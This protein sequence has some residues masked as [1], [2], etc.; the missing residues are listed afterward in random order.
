MYNI[1][2]ALIPSVLRNGDV[3]LMS[4]QLMSRTYKPP[5]AAFGVSLHVSR[6]RSSVTWLVSSTTTWHSTPSDLWILSYRASFRCR[7][8]LAGDVLEFRIARMRR[9]INLAAKRSREYLHT[10]REVKGSGART[11]GFGIFIKSSH[12]K[13]SF[14]ALPQ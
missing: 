5:P 3:W 10:S 12:V 14:Y 9:R 6:Q 8:L 4:H 1:Q 2:L 13:M 11:I 7:S